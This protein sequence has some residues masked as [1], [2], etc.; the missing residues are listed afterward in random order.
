M[1]MSNDEIANAETPEGGEG[2]SR[3]DGGLEQ[4]EPFD[5]ENYSK[6]KKKSFDF[7]KQSNER[8]SFDFETYA[9]DKGPFID[10]KG[11][12]VPDKDEGVARGSGKKAAGESA[13]GSTIR[14]SA[15]LSHR[16][17][18]EGSDAELV[19]VPDEPSDST[20]NP[21][22]STPTRVSVPFRDSAPAVGSALWQRARANEK[23][24]GFATQ[25]D[26]ADSAGQTEGSPEEH[27]EKHREELP[28]ELRDEHHERHHEKH[29]EKRS[30]ERRARQ[31]R[32]LPGKRS[33]KRFAL[34]GAAENTAGD[35][36]SGSA[37]AGE[38]GSVEASGASARIGEQPSG[39]SPT[40]GRFTGVTVHESDGRT[41]ETS[42]QPHPAPSVDRRPPATPR[43]S[44]DAS[45][46]TAS[47]PE[48]VVHEAADSVRTVRPVQSV[49]FVASSPISPSSSSSASS[50]SV[51]S[52]ESDS[53]HADSVSL[54]EDSRAA[55]D[56]RGRHLHDKPR[57]VSALDGL[58]SF[59]VIA[60]ILYHMGL[61]WAP[62]G[63]MG[64]TVFFVISGYLINGLLVSE[65]ER[66]GSISLTS[67]W[68]R[69]ARRL[70]PAILLSVVGTAA[71]CTLF[72][73]VL[74]DKMRPDIIPSLLFYNNW[75]QVFRDL[76][77]FEAAGSPSPLT[78]FWSLS[79]EEQFYVVWP[80]LLLLLYRIGL[81]KRGISRIALA[82][83]VFSAIEMA[84]LYNPMG[85]PSRIYYGTDT[86]AMSL[87][88]G[89]W[90]AVAWPSAAFGG[91]EAPEH[92]DAA[93]LALNVLGVLSLAGLVAIVV[94]TN[95][96]SS[97]P[98]HGGI[99]LTTVLSAVLIAA[100][101]VPETWV[102]KLFA[103][104]PLVWIGKRSYGMYL[105]HFPIL[106]L[107]TDPNSTQGVPWWMRLVQ[108]ALIIVV[109]AL[110]YTFVED[111]IRKGRVGEWLRVR[112]EDRTRQGGSKTFNVRKSSPLQLFVSSAC[113][114]ALLGIACYGVF[115]VP[116]TDYAAQ[117]AGATGQT[118][119]RDEA[120]GT[121]GESAESGGN[122]QTEASG[123]DSD[124]NAKAET[125]E[126][127]IYVEHLN[128]DGELI[129]EPLL[130]GDS[131]SAGAV[132]AFYEAFPYGHIDAVVNRNIW[133]SPYAD[134]RDAGQAG[135]CVVLCLGTN[136]A[137]VDW[138]ID[139]E[140]LAPIG[141]DKKIFMVNTRNTRDWM[142]GTNAELASAAER[143]PNVVLID[144]FGASEGHD[145][146]FAGDGTHLTEEGAQ[147]YIQL[148]RDAIEESFE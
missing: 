54:H 132:D 128:S 83:A 79:I 116:P 127:A 26:T 4:W 71:L 16:P 14:S 50:A 84:L 47:R 130:I 60:V 123:D 91:T 140:L 77:Y 89:V 19:F 76:S 86:R 70:F 137:V 72:N 147:A 145:E 136:N 63:L 43:A 35:G 21:Q 32:N 144:W 8:E 46:R 65:R 98:Y 93:R 9:Q 102:A 7:D 52:T 113:F 6:N 134:Y 55:A 49:Q 38:S 109:S 148:I 22:D 107:T 24:V 138:Q 37:E 129:Y 96:F 3:V 51:S 69:R 15:R 34:S 87:L 13:G 73:H 29:H 121:S 62:G 100:L 81:G 67:F 42:A 143:H 141:E 10:E 5:F 106:L 119:E 61:G 146:Y 28:E 59:A 2:L 88:V 131:V 11:F 30:E 25:V 103:L 117:L 68:L 78:H 112:K 85:D 111:P 64:V 125:Y 90:L 115:A 135:D 108:V 110:S 57:Y 20:E 75:W 1:K 118:S 126:E 105:W 92:G 114:A 39:G 53:Q 27:H 31:P 99:A 33:E 82:L 58:R 124:L 101:V 122:G 56:G 36:R 48:V 12:P 23:A 40:S 133:E 45:N 95:G 17:S 74:L 97:F 41:V 66:T 139:D 80:L 18:R 94:L 142:E 120:Q 104:K 44:F